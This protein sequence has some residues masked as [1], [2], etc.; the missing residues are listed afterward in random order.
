[1]ILGPLMIG[2][3]IYIAAYGWVRAFRRIV[4]AWLLG[5]KYGIVCLLLFLPVLV[6]NLMA[7]SVPGAH[8]PNRWLRLLPLLLLVSAPFWS[9]LLIG[10]VPGAGLRGTSFERFDPEQ[11]SRPLG[12]PGRPAGDRDAPT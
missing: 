5:F 8:S 6:F 3:L 9:F 10:Y 4:S 7:Q 2:A 1:I 11:F 12:D